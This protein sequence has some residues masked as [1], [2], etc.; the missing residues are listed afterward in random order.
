MYTVRRPP[1]LSHS[2]SAPA[3]CKEK[4]ISP[5]PPV[6]T[7]TQTTRCPPAL[8]NSTA[9]NFQIAEVSAEKGYASRA[10]TGAV[11][12]GTA[13]LIHEMCEL[14]IDPVFWPESA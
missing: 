8:V 10:N 2:L 6:R 1:T 11:T 4:L 3:A 5:N 12:A 7:T 9:Q 14:A 13:V